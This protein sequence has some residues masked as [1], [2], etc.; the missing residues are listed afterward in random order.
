MTVSSVMA[1]KRTRSSAKSSFGI[2]FVRIAAEGGLDAA[3]EAGADG[4]EDSAG[5]DTFIDGELR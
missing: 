4:D 2:E 1:R 5:C 3:I